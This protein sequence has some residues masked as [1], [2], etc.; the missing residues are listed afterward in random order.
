MLSLTE[1][2][3]L[4]GLSAEEVQ[5][6]AEHEGVPEIV[7]AEIGFDLVE[8]PRGLYRLHSIFLAE[9]EKAA[10]KRQ[11]ERT[12]RIDRVYRRFRATYPMPRV[13]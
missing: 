5:V 4:S 1:C 2:V 3:D 8:T 12:R 13:L 11:H 10:Q 6:I 9:L 7:A